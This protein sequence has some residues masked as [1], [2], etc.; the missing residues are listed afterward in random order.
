MLR[1]YCEV[2]FHIVRSMLLC[3]AVIV[4]LVKTLVVRVVLIVVTFVIVL[5]TVIAMVVVIVV[6]N[7]CRTSRLRRRWLHRPSPL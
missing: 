4:V 5:V 6:A 3:P 1:S 2:L 7:V